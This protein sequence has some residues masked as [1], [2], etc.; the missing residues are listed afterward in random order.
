[1]SDYA[2]GD[3]Q[4]CFEPLLRLLS[5]IQFNEDRDRLWFTGDLVNRG[6]DSLAVLRFIKALP[7]PARITLGNHDLYCLSRLFQ[8]GLLP[9]S[10]DTL[11]PLLE[12]PDAHVLGHWLRVQPI[13]YY[14]EALNVVMS[15]AGIA[16]VWNL[17]Q[18]QA[19]ARELELALSSDDYHLYLAYLYGNQPTHWQSN[20]KGMDRLRVICNYFTRM[21]FCTDA[22][23]LSFGYKGSLEHAPKTLYPWFSVP[24]R[25]DISADIVFGHWAALNGAAIHP[26]IH[27]LDTG[28]VWGRQLT[29]L[30]LQDK[31]RFS[32]HG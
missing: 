27:A 23:Q 17:S 22:G 20:L 4:G 10:D 31:K 26:R 18:A 16:P 3:V 24:N 28:C 1:M 2:I 8:T 15:H 6:P 32:V 25:Q 12:A 21:R 14:D 7:Q 9:D 11:T 19:Y 13:L 29:A 5:H 30:R